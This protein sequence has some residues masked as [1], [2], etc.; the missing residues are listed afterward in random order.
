MRALVHTT[1]RK[2]ESKLSTKNN[3]KNPM[4]RNNNNKGILF[5]DFTQTKTPKDSALK[6]VPYVVFCHAMHSAAL[7]T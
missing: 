7:W 6:A 4:Q 2:N 5:G 3:E 1:Q